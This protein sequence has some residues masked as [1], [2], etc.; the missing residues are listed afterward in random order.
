MK[1]VFMMNF[2]LFFLF[3]SMKTDLTKKEME[4]LEEKPENCAPHGI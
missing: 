1:F 3:F 2:I 4:R